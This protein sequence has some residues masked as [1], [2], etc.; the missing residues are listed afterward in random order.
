[1]KRTITQLTSNIE[2]YSALSAPLSID[3]ELDGGI[4]KDILETLNNKATSKPYLHLLSEPSEAAPV[5]TNGIDGDLYLLISNPCI[6]FKKIQNIW[7]LVEKTNDMFFYCDVAGIRKYYSF[8]DD[9]V[10]IILIHQIDFADPSGGAVKY[11]PQTLTTQQ[12]D[13][14]RLNINAASKAYIDNVIESFKQSG[15]IGSS[16]AGSTMPWFGTESTIPQDWARII[17]TQKWY[18]KE[19]YNS[20]YLALGGESNIF[21]LTSTHFSIPY[22]PEGTSVIQLG[23]NFPRGTNGGS[24]EVVLDNTQVPAT[25]TKVPGIMGGDNSDNNNTTHFAGGDKPN[26]QGDAFTIDV[27]NNGGGLAHNNMPPYAPAY[28]IIK[29]RNTGGSFVASINEQGH[30]ILTFDDGSIQDVGKWVDINPV[31]GLPLIISSSNIEIPI[32]NDIW[33]KEINIFVLSGNPTVNVPSINSGD[34]TGQDFYPSVANL[35]LTSGS[36]LQINISGGEVKIQII[37]YNI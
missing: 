12:Q 29:L 37:K 34:M 5:N 35:K 21:G 22:F 7:S 8:S 36:N 4:K 32:T 2:N 20:L 16:V 1:M 24:K 6:L 3:P 19:D 23:E 18:S 15:A 27:Q 10:D 31:F 14:A 26:G 17:S 9:L 11:T 25:V 13:Q 33:I 30:L 28:W